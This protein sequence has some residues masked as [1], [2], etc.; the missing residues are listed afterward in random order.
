M[1][2]ITPHARNSNP[3]TK[4]AMSPDKIASWAGWL[5][6]LTVWIG[7]LAAI[8]GAI[9][10]ATGIGA[11]I[12]RNKDAANKKTELERFKAGANERAA[13]F[14][15]ETAIAR[16]D[17]ATLQSKMAWRTITPEQRS[18]IVAELKARAPNG[19]ITMSA[20][21]MDLEG[22][23]FQQQ[24]ATMLTA[25]GYAV[26]AHTAMM[27]SGPSGVGTG[28]VLQINSE[29][30]VPPHAQAIL[31]AFAKAGLNP[32]IAFS[33]STPKGELHIVVWPKGSAP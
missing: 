29:R 33:E 1:Q 19:P 23:A 2:E 31:E 10:A 18:A 8:A 12:F 9:A 28:L 14:E 26:D 5:T 30:D 11:L 20:I 4:T 22:V 24:I 21:E 32:K 6:A 17:L 7:A 13:A 25:A 15:K 27:M 16:L 3:H